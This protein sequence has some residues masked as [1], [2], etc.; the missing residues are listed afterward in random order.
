MNFGRM[1]SAVFLHAD[2]SHLIGNLFFFYCFSSSIERE[3]SIRAYL[4][5]FLGFA[6]VTHISYSLLANEALP[7]LGLSGVVWGYM[8]LFLARFPFDRVKCFLWFLWIIRTVSL[9]SA[10]FVLGFLIMDIGAFR[11]HE[12]GVNHVAHFSGFF[13]GLLFIGFWG[14]LERDGASLSALES[15]RRR[16]AKN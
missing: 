15:A 16:R 4:A 1:I 2:L 10:V 11:A 14:L 13:C 8:G 7:S 6:I 9:P 3:I 5:T 12:P